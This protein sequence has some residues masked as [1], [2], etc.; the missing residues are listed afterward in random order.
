[1]PCGA[2]IVEPVEPVE[3]VESIERVEVV[4]VVENRRNI[5]GDGTSTLRALPADV[6]YP[7]L[8]ERSSTRSGAG[9]GGLEK[10]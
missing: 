6:E 5:G 1:V 3:P 8:V 7:R 9:G 4:E 10:M 2:G